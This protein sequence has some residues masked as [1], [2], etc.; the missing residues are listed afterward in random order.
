[1]PKRIFC[2]ILPLAALLFAGCEGIESAINSITIHGSGKPASEKREVR[3]FHAVRLSGVGELTVRQG[4]TESLSIE[5][6]D[7]ILPKI[8]TEVEDGRLTIGVERGVSIRP[9]LPVRYTLV[10]TDLTDL[11]LSGSGKVIT[12]P[13]QCGDL[14]V[15]LS[16][17][18]DMQLESLAADTLQ[19]SISGSGDIRI[20]GQA[21]RQEIQISGSGD[22]GG[23]DLESRSAEVSVSGSGDSTLWVRD[24]LDVRVSGSGDVAYYGSPAVTRKVSGS[25]SLRNLG[26][27]R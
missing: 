27:R 6:E 15:R 18:G 24:T 19:V 13:L 4:G 26:E 22:Y 23:K 9:T 17:S 3:G 2:V 5:A 14:S 8:V 21:A 20:T 16:G 10:V 1:M 11:Q 7:N 25:G 12:G